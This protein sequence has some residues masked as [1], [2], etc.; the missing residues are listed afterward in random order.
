MDCT[1]PDRNVS[2]PNTSTNDLPELCDFKKN[3][4]SDFHWTWYLFMTLLAGTT[5]SANLTSIVVLRR[6]RSTLT[7][8]LRLALMNLSLTDVL[9]IIP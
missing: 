1:S 3:C 5:F 9:F 8:V 4:S 7:P 6:L 2:F